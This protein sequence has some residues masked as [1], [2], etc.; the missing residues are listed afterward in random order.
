MSKLKFIFLAVPLIFVFSFNVNADSEVIP[1]AKPSSESAKTSNANVSSAP[2]SN[3]SST[4][5]FTSTTTSETRSVGT[6][7][8][9]VVTAQKR[10]ESL[11]DAPIA[12]TAITESTIDDLDIANVVDLAG[13]APNVHII[14]TPSNNTAATIA[15]RGGTT[16]NPA[17]TWE[18]TVG[19]YLDGVYLG[20]GQGSIFDVADL[21]RVEILRGPQGT[22][23]GRNTLG[24]AINLISK[25]PSGAGTSAK[26]T[27]GNYGLKQSQLIGDYAIGEDVYAKV[28]LN[29]KVRGGYV[30]NAASP[31]QAAQGV[32]P[33]STSGTEL[34]TIDSK[35]FK[36]TVAYEGEKTNV[37]LSLDKTDQDNKP[38][39]A[40][41]T[42][43]I[44]NWS[45]AF[46]VGASARTGGL[47]LWPIEL[48]TNADRQN[49]AHINTPTY[50]T[51]IV[52]GTSLTIAHETNL[53]TLKVIWA[54]RTT[55]WDDRLDLDGGPFPIAETERH[56]SYSADSLEIQLAGSTDN[57]EYVV[58][59]YALEDDAFTANPQ[60]FFGGGQVFAQEY[61]GRGDS[62]A[63]F[64]QFT[65]AF[66][67]NWDITV[68]GRST[69]EYKQGYKAYAGT[70]LSAT[71][72]DNFDD[73]NTTFIL[74]NDYSENT[75]LYFKI[76]EGFKAG[77][78]NAESSD[79][80]AATTPYAPET[81]TSTEFGL[82]GRYFDN[83]MLLN[84]A[85]FDNEHKDMQISY[86]TAN[87]AAA[88]EVINNSAD[89]SG[90]EIETVTI[91]DDSTRF[92]L[93]I[94]TLDSEFTGNK[95]ASDGFKL[96]QVPYSPET[97]IYASLEKDFGDYRMRLDHSRIGEH[98]TFPYNSKDPRAAL[99]TLA[100]RGTTDFRILTEPM[101]NLQLNFWI[102]NLTDEGHRMSSIP[103][104]PA[105]GQLT[106]SYFS[107]PRTIG[108]DLHYKF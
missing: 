21:E 85:Y 81:I 34:D 70:T 4:G 42:N 43:T 107:A 89:I 48:F 94:G 26:V 51:S 100:S 72:Q 75:N 92:M 13:M 77:G 58:G 19:M 38:P 64:G 9:V 29:S 7:E 54:K 87:A 46:G 24:G 20:K 96:E 15:M 57:M 55:D 33:N 68:G 39:F 41:L 98:P 69:E 88:S 17:I 27:F 45:T 93:N 60:S 66:A 2:T 50:E 97:T 91:I 105:F 78:F 80:V 35:G 14:N 106:L 82:K 6:L 36:F 10:E 59:Y 76:A 102:K 90:L 40:Q 3:A 99:T 101:E 37:T 53:G 95:V 8:E 104:G 22:L 86:F 65:Y 79:F 108:M 47:K 28:V 44:P 73:T 83:R 12:I 11:Q 71:G 74:S 23:Y 62:T 18:P 52:E 16:I 5:M 61:K 103:F 30:N 1:V 32:V 67:E 31:Y 84:I 25:K 56:T 49:V 63:I